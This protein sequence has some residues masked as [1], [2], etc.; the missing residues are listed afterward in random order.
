[1]RKLNATILLLVGSVAL[2]GLSGCEQVEQATNGVVEK[3]RQ[4]AVQVLDEAQQS[5]SIDQARE[6][7]N[8]ALSEAR[9]LAAGLLGQASEYLTQDQPGED[10][11][12]PVAQDLTTEL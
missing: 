10:V 11:E 12:R 9:R 1:M 3:A 5:G 2:V 7:A 8:Q 4:A 6:T